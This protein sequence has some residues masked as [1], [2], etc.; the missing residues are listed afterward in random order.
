ML[1]V[2]IYVI[3]GVDVMIFDVTGV[4]LTPGNFGRDCFGN[5]KYTNENGEVIECCCDECDYFLCCYL[6]V[7]CT[8]CTNDSC[9]RYNGYFKDF[10]KI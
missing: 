5:G 3:I 6:S 4:I 10:V 7:D 1:Y 9:P 8:K 2:I